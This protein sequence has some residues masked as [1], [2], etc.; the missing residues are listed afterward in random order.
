M[1]G[2]L[3]LLL[4]RHPS[5]AASIYPCPHAGLGAEHGIMHQAFSVALSLAFSNDTVP[6]SPSRMPFA[7][8]RGFFWP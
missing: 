5:T 2:L 1:L 4:N 3:E 6:L 8:V 7:S